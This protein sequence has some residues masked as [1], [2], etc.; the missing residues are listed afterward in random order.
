MLIRLLAVTLL[1]I[2]CMAQQD[3]FYSP[4]AIDKCLKKQQ[5]ITGKLTLLTD[6]NPF[7]LRGDFF[8]DGVPGYAVTVRIPKGDRRNGVLVCA[9]NGR[10]FLL[11]GSEAHPFSDM[12]EDR[13]VA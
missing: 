3:E 5:S 7:Y 9:A 8:G 2:T 6:V 12:P 10:T 4:P 13:F 1:S 11:G